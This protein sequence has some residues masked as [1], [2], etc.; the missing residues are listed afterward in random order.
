MIA[1]GDRLLGQIAVDV[2]HSAVIVPENAN[3]IRPHSNSNAGGVNPLLKFP[4]TL[5]RPGDGP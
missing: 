3:A 5:R 2:E 1:E 4:A